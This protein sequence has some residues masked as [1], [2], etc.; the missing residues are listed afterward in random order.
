MRWVVA[1]GWL[2]FAALA[3]LVPDELREWAA[4]EGTIEALSHGLLMVTALAF[5]LAVARGPG[6]ARPALVMVF[7]LWLLAEEV[8]YGAVWGVTIIADALRSLVDESNLHNAWSGAS[9]I[10]FGVPLLWLYGAALVRPMF[11]EPPPDPWEGRGP[12]IDEARAFILLSIV[13][14]VA[15]FLAES[16][17]PELD[18]WSEMLLYVILLSTA[19]RTAGLMPGT[20]PEA[21]QV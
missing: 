16:W 8:D 13:A 11:E 19:A 20:G 18:E 6:R 1:I 14:I 3:A 7:T 4:K 10:L 21:S 15:P 5:A 2:C 9:Y 12:S 17:E